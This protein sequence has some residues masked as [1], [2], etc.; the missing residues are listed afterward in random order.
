MIPP[1]CWCP[2]QVGHDRCALV[3]CDWYVLT[4]VPTVPPN[5]CALTGVSLGEA[6]SL[7]GSPPGSLQPVRSPPTQEASA[8]L[9]TAACPALGLATL[10]S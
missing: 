8:L 2:W 9:S 3:G 10:E 6:G 7:S 4:G 1:P 5:R